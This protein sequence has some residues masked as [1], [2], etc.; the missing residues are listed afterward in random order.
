VILE[1]VNLMIVHIGQVDIRVS[2]DMSVLP[3]YGI[4]LLSGL[5]LAW[6]E[7]REHLVLILTQ[8][9]PFSWRAC[10]GTDWGILDDL[11]IP[12]LVLLLRNLTPGWLVYVRRF[13]REL[14]HLDVHFLVVLSVGVER[15]LDILVF[16]IYYGHWN[17]SI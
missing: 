11:H 15:P 9:V 12:L 8:L 4:Y 14:D 10:Y 17:F 2:S 6:G 7:L 5:E 3:R 16:V 1:V 13:L